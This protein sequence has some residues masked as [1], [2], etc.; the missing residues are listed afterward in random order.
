MITFVSDFLN[1]RSHGSHIS[2][3]I[4]SASFFGKLNF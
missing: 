4:C 3:V 2:K 1:N